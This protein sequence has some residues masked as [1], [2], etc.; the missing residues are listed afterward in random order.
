MMFNFLGFLTP[1]IS[2]TVSYPT[3][4]VS[5]FAF[6]VVVYAVYRFI[7]FVRYRRV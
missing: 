1:F 7:D 5:V 2:G 3:F 4:I 6:V